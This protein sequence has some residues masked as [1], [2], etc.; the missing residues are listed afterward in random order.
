[1]VTIVFV[2][3]ARPLINIFTTDPEVV[4]YGIDALRYISYGYVFYAYGM[5][6]VASFNGA[7]DTTTPTLINLSCY[8]LFQ[9]PLAYTLALPLKF[10]ARGVFVAICIAES[11]IAVVGMLIFRRGSWKT[12]KI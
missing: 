2:V 3:F 12:R 4:P 10:G 5:V 11:T 6:M 9:I 8:W 1:L 7:G